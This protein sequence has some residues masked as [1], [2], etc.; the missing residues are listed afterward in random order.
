MPEFQQSWQCYPEGWKYAQHHTR[1]QEHVGVVTGHPEYPPMSAGSEKISII[2]E[3]C[4]CNI[5]NIQRINIKK[6][7]ICK[8]I[9]L[10]KSFEM[11]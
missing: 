6:R 8:N 11:F 1:Q 10:L 4:I 2:A 7:K 9:T 3:I 5:C